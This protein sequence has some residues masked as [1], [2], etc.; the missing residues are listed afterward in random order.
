MVA[1]AIAF[2]TVACGDDGRSTNADG[3]A[4][5]SVVATTSVVGDFVSQVGGDRVDLTVVL[6]PNV[7]AHDYE[8]SPADI[9]AIRGA[10]VVVRNGVGLEVW[11]D[12]TIQASGT[13][14]AIVDASDG[15]AIYDTVADDDHTDDHDGH[16]HGDGHDHGDGDPHIW[17]DPTNAQRMVANIGAALSAA[18]PAGT[19][20][21]EANVD[22]YTDL[23]VDLD[24]EIRDAVA[25]VANRKLVTNHDAFRYYAQ[26]YGFEVV[27]AVIPSFDSSAELSGKGLDALVQDIRRHGVKAVFAESSLPGD[28]ARTIADE[29]GVAVVTG[30]AALYGDGLGP[31]GSG[32]STYLDMM[33]HNTNTIVA[34]LK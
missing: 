29:A 27:G 7:D 19:A 14:A 21:Y 23:L 31:A 5:L 33:R 2:T 30:D 11:F 15:V 34:N 3:S 25:Q 16:S 12:A 20:F 4:R 13:D 24:Q 17:Q 8:P 1:A 28:A 6:K 18:D 10:D 22:A 9:E 32:A 26:R